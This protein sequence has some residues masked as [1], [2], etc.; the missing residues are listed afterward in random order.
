MNRL[1]ENES[2]SRYCNR[3]QIQ[4][5]IPVCVMSSEFFTITPPY[6]V[7]VKN[8]WMDKIVL[9][10]FTSNSKKL[11]WHTFHDYLTCEF[12]AHYLC[13]CAEMKRKSTLTTNRFNPRILNDYSLLQSWRVRLTNPGCNFPFFFL[14]YYYSRTLVTGHLIKSAVLLIGGLSIEVQL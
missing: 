10:T 6:L 9:K 14:Q 12:T 5:C 13:R 2:V 3:S 1:F 11:S 8:F 7:R 4:I